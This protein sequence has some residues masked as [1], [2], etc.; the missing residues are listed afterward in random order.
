M[1]AAIHLSCLKSARITEVKAWR[2]NIILYTL[3]G[4]CQLLK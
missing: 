3:T 4:L 1:N 2:C